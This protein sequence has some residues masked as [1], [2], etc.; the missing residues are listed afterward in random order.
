MDRGES[1]QVRL[2]AARLLPPALAAAL[3]GML[4]IVSTSAV[5][6]QEPPPDLAAK[7]KDA[8]PQDSEAGV[9]GSSG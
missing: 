8:T 3:L 4:A 9:S 5:M 7:D 1:R 2:P 6:A